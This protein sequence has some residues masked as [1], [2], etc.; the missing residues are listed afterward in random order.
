MILQLVVVPFII[1]L[2]VQVWSEF[3]NSR[4]GLFWFF[5]WLAIWSGVGIIVFFPQ[6]TVLLAKVLGI[7]RGVDSIIYLSVVTTFYL[8]FRLYLKISRLNQRISKLVQEDALK[9]NDKKK[10]EVCQFLMSKNL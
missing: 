9:K 6:V 1:I 3:K 8:I 10:F 5:F 2:L 7:Q 4:L